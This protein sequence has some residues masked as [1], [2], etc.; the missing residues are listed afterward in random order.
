MKQQKKTR[1]STHIAVLAFGVIGSAPAFADPSPAL[2]RFSLWLGGFYSDTQTQIGATGRSGPLNGYN[3][4]FSLENDLGFQEHKAV[5]RARFDFLIGDHQGFSF[6]YFGINRT[7]SRSISR[8]IDFDG[9]VFPAS[10]RVDGKLDF[11]F[12]SAS[13]RYWFG[14]GN[15]AFGLGIGAAYYGVKA[16]FAGEADVDGYSAQAAA[17]T[18][19]TAWAPVLQLGWRHAFTRDLR[20][21]ADAYGVKKNGGNLAGH[22]YNAAVG[23]EWFPIEHLGVGA[24]YSYTRI[25]LDQNHPAYQ[26]DLDLKMQGPSLFARLRW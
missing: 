19:D 12:G 3:G 21:Y 16:R 13:Y 18:H 4:H 8:D 10:A 15:D 6:D 25:R 7:H 26:A 1:L 5:P 20:I 11:N 9:D 22:I 14:T 17:S 24:E 2:D 23:M